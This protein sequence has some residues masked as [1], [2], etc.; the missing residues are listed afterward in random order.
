MKDRGN[1][2]QMKIGFG[3]KGARIFYHGL[4]KGEIW[5]I[6]PMNNKQ[7]IYVQNPMLWM[8]RLWTLQK[9]LS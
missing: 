3:I 1:N 9:E 6:W 2:T 4:E 8:P 5:Q 7:N